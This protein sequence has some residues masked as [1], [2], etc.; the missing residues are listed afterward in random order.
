MKRLLATA[1]LILSPSLFAADYEFDKVHTQITFS[2]SHLGFSTSTGSFVDFDGSFSFDESDFSKS[3]VEV[4]IKTKSI[5]LNDKTWNSHM[6]GE[7]W[8]DV[9]KFPT[10]VFKS[11]S[12]KKTG[13]KTMDVMGNLTLKGVTKPAT[14]NVTFNKAGKAFGK[15]KAGFSAVTTIDRAEFGFTKGIPGVGGKI[16]VRIEVEGAKK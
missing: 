15:E 9:K 3:N 4:T 1:L 6:R 11:T 12:V 7:K 8:F 2:V 5:D 13:D 10:M 16:P 14:L